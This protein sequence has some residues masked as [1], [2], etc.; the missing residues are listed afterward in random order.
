MGNFMCVFLL[1]SLGGRREGGERG[2]GKNPSSNSLAE[3]DER[4]ERRKTQE[5]G[6][7]GR[8]SD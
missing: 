3:E 2:E 8:V 4:G 5:G 6:K 7:R 1:F